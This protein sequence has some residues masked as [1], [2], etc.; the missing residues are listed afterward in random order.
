MFALVMWMLYCCGCAFIPC[1]DALRSIENDPYDRKDY[2]CVDKAISYHRQLLAQGFKSKFI[3]GNCRCSETNHAW[4]EVFN[5]ASGK[6][7]VIDPTWIGSEDGWPVDMQGVLSK[8]GKAERLRFTEWK[9]GVT[10]T[11]VVTRNKL[12]IGKV[13]PENY[14]IRDTICGG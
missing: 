14:L 8:F 1:Q 9:A 5:P 6:W 12:M 10:K 7:Y 11:D 2:N 4:V 3:T 13:Y